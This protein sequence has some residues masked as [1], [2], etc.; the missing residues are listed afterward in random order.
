MRIAA[1]V[2]MMAAGPGDE[3]NT[4]VKEAVGAELPALVELY[5]WFHANAELSLKEE[6]TSA[7]FAAGLREA[8]WTVTDHVGGF[9]V[10]GVLRN[11]EGPAI[12][13]RI[14]MDALPVKEETG[15]VGINPAAGPPSL[16]S[17]PNPV[18][19]VKKFWGEFF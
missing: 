11:G 4:P 18:V 5:T 13:L 17:L 19:R 9:G 12:L 3:V 6:K 2:M 7:K 8:G 14:D 10:V 16:K 1:M 15:S